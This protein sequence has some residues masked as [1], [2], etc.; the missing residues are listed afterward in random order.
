M[1]EAYTKA[2]GRGMGFAFGRI[3][4]NLLTD[5]L[6]IDGEIPNGWQLVK[7]EIT[8]DKDIYQG[9]AARFVGGEETVVQS[10]SSQSADWLVQYD[11]ASIVS[12]IIEALK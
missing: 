4:Y 9:V 5:S 3:E 12:E 6:T 11:A 2:L 7:F 1:K 10:R 8:C